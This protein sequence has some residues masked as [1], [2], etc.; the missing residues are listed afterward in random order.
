M[1]ERPF[2]ELAT[3]DQGV[4]LE[5]CALDIADERYVDL[6]LV[7]VAS[8][9]FSLHARLNR[10]QVEALIVELQAARAEAWPAEGHEGEDEE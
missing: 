7:D 8:S 10:C 5:V 3:K 6:E 9:A 4:H 2:V 1:V